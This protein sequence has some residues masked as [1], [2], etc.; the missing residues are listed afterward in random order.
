MEL[1]K[2]TLLFRAKNAPLMTLPIW[3][4]K[5]MIAEAVAKTALV[6]EESDPIMAAPQCGQCQT[7]ASQ[8]CGVSKA[9]GVQ[10]RLC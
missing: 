7:E 10:E 3:K 5:P 8:A 4:R 6:S 2:E 9:V 1:S